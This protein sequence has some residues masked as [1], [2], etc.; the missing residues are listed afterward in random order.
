M[1]KFP[2]CIQ[3]D[4]MDCGAACIKMITEYNGQ[5]IDLAAIKEIWSP[6]REGVSLSTI[7]RTLDFYGYT[8]VGGKLTIERLIEK[9]PLPAIIH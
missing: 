1:K 2:I 3:H 4:V 7:G 5:L 6:T 9:Q 8:T